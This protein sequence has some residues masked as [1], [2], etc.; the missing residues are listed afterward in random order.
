MPVR[1][2]QEKLEGYQRSIAFLAWSNSLLETLPKTGALHN[3]FDRASLSIPL[4]IADG[5]G[6]WSRKDRCRYFDTAGG[7]ALE[8]AAILDSAEARALLDTEVAGNGKEHPAPIV[9]MP[10]GLIQANDPERTLE[11]GS[12][13]LGEESLGYGGEKEND[14]EKEKEE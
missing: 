1:F 2:D 9:R 4:H 13:R 7:S 8:C 10:I 3:P 14:Q 6:K 12:M 11:R 5:T